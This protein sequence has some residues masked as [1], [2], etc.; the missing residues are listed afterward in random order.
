MLS[1]RQ[2]K[3]VNLMANI[4]V[5]STIKKANEKGNKIS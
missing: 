2:E 5:N 1:V 4:I 3:A